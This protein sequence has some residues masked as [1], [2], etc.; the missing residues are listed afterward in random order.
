MN[1]KESLATRTDRNGKIPNWTEE[2]WNFHEAHLPP[3]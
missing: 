1:C 2:N 3:K